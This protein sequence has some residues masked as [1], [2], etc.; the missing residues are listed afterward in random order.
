LLVPINSRVARWSADSLP[1]DWRAQV[2]RWDRFHSIRVTVI[3]AA[4]A[5]LVIATVGS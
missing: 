2:T 3:V 4:F 5:L 1:P